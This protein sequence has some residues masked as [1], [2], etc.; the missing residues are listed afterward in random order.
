MISKK[1]TSK[2]T[3]PEHVNQKPLKV[4]GWNQLLLSS[5]CKAWHS[6]Q[7]SFKAVSKAKRYIFSLNHF[8]HE[9]EILLLWDI[10]NTIWLGVAFMELLSREAPGLTCQGKRKIKMV[11][12]SEMSWLPPRGVAALNLCFAPTAAV[13]KWN[14]LSG[15]RVSVC[16]CASSSKWALQ[17]FQL[18]LEDYCYVCLFLLFMLT[19]S[20]FKSLPESTV[21]R[22]E[23]QRRTKITYFCKN[24]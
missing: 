24:N 13:S 14:S 4:S 1:C 18:L 17:S 8:Q 21:A 2:P 11:Q 7:C 12:F 9:S 5:A 16:S 23:Q 10:L 22:E 6:G 3:I 19:N 20:V 15:W